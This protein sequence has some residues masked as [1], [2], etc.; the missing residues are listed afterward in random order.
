ME[1]IRELGN[2]DSDKDTDL[3]KGA[4]KFLRKLATN[5]PRLC[6]YNIKLLLELFDKSHYLYR[7]AILK[8]LGNIVTDFLQR[9]LDKEDSDDSDSSIEEEDVDMKDGSPTKTQKVHKLYT[10]TKEEFIRQIQ[11]R[12]ND[13]ISHVRTKA[14]K[15]CV[16]IVA[17]ESIKLEHFEL[18]QSLIEDCSQTM[19]D[20]TANVR[21]NALRLFQVMIAKFAK[22]HEENKFAPLRSIMGQVEVTRS[23]LDK[24]RKYI[25][26]IQ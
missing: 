2:T 15:I 24:I 26:D 23:D 13:K 8:I 12:F 11:L 20:Q 25:V 21:K 9:E 14:L 19:R 5:T 3:V 18:F 1:R 4:S 6:Y 16:K 22:C 7:Q 17:T 10:E